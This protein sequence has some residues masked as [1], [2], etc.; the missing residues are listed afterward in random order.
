M[1]TPVAF[2]LVP[3]L[4]F[5]DFITYL[6]LHIELN[7]QIRDESFNDFDRRWKQGQIDL[8]QDI[9]D[10]LLGIRVNHMD[11]I[12]LLMKEIEEAYT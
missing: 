9:I 12:L 4:K 8:L 11:K 5:F 7:K 6:L 1:T 2:T 10:D 3:K